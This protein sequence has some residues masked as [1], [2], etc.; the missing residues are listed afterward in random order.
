MPS[1]PSTPPQSLKILGGPQGGTIS[2]LVIG[3]NK[4]NKTIWI[5]S[6]AG[7]YRST[8]FEN[9]I[10]QGWERLQNAP[11]GIM[12]L[13]RSPNFADDHTLIAGTHLGVYR[14][15][16]GGDTWHPAQMPLSTSM[17]LCLCFSP[18]YQSD[19]MV[20]AGT[21]DD[22]VF[23]SNSRGEQ[24]KSQGFGVYDPDVYAL[25]FSPQFSQN[26]LIFAGTGT[27]VYYSY[28]G[29]RAWRSLPFPDETGPVLCLALIN[30]KDNPEILFAGTEAKGL[31]VSYDQGQNWIKNDLP[32]TC[33]N[34]LTTGSTGSDLIVA[35]NTGIY[36]SGDEGETW[37]QL[38]DQ[39]DALTV[40]KNDD[41]LL[42]GFF[43]QGVW[44]AMDNQEWEPVTGLPLRIF[45]GQAISPHFDKD[46]TAFLFGPEEG[47][48]M[49]EDGGLSWNDQN[50]GLPS[51]AINALAL[52]PNFDQDRT[53]LAAST[54]GIFRSEDAGLSWTVIAE[55]ACQQLTYSPNGKILLG[56]FPGNG[57]RISEDQGQSWQ[58]LI[59][60][61]DRTGGQIL[62]LA[63]TNLKDYYIAHIENV[64]ENI[65][66]WQGKPGQFEKVVSEPA[67]ENPHVCFWF[68]TGAAVNR[69]WFMSLGNQVWKIS[70][71]SGM[72]EAP[73]SVGSGILPEAILALK[74]T[75]DSEGQVILYACTGRRIYRSQDAKAWTPIYDFGNDRAIAFSLSTT[76]S[77]DQT[78]Y[79]LLLGGLLC[80]LEL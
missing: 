75:Q 68:P 58:D 55:E 61:W 71:R 72:V 26:G 6:P 62:A 24:W 41:V 40:I 25:A 69:P 54:D 78:A 53:I 28:N 13:V 63:V 38:S 76:F 49:T 73:A 42:A 80:S 9:G 27:T 64:G 77:S 21:L 47:I 32:A 8:G 46:E 29:S 65:T 43:D 31:Y 37:K 33:I 50:E 5:S 34:A 14:S 70:S 74:G 11:L 1:K 44:L 15:E 22:S 60:S 35:T 66:L 56:S 10:I 30:G 36:Q 48:W 4:N 39:P 7:L 18:D 17:I 67:G 3:Q 12:S 59:G 51:L 79:A 52:S 16:N 19:G 45:L 2:S 23:V 57:L 20:L